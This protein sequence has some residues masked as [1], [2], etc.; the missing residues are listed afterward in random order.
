[1]LHSALP[2]TPTSGVH[3]VGCGCGCAFSASES[4]LVEGLNG[5]VLG[6]ARYTC[7]IGKP[8]F[9]DTRREAFQRQRLAADVMGRERVGK[10]LWA[11]ADLSSAVAITKGE[12]R[13]RYTGLQTCGSVWM[14]PVCAGRVAE[15]RRREMNKALAAA[16]AEG[17]AVFLMTLTFRHSAD[18]GLADT[19][20]ALK[21]SM[22]AFRNHRSFATLRKT[23]MV[24]T[25][26]AT[27]MT[28]GHH[29]WHPHAHILV[30]WKGD[31]EEGHEALE[32]LREPWLASLA[33]QDREGEGAAF[34]L[35]DG[36]AAGKYVAKWGAAEELTLGGK[37]TGKAGGL[38]PW[39]ILDKTRHSARAR[40]L[41]FEYAMATKGRRALVWSPGL[42]ARFEVDDVSD[43]E[44]AEASDQEA[45]DLVE[46]VI[47]TLRRE[48][49]IEARKRGRARLLEAAEAGGTAAVIGVLTVQQASSD[50]DPQ[51]PPRG[52]QGSG[53]GHRNDGSGEAARPNGPPRSAP[54]E[55]PPQA[56]NKGQ[57]CPIP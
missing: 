39:Q 3:P 52:W 46:S 13:A 54:R 27:E 40:G 44:A 26:V 55:G 51:R 30:F 41:F 23:G 19:L 29:G 49:W 5:E 28:H 22:K 14:C 45:A 53:S 56:A 10:C 38:H 24:G 20:T 11:V 7:E 16:R 34:D 50:P 12:K 42:K 21:A 35:R 57:S 33:G 17:L 47:I 25:V 8:L 2:P 32:A 36:S 31:K 1:M 18:E 6:A 43:E 9:E 15:T 48:E 4:P 37:K